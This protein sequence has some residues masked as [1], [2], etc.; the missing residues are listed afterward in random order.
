L[1]YIKNMSKIVKKSLIN[2]INNNYIKAIKDIYTRNAFM[3]ESQS[4]LICTHTI[5]GKGVDFYLTF[6]KN[7]SYYYKIGAWYYY[8][9]QKNRRYKIVI[10][11]NI[12]NNF[13]TNHYSDIHIRIKA[14]LI[15]EI[16]HHLQKLKAPTREHLPRKNYASILDYAKSPSELEACLKHMYFIHKKTKISFIKLI[17]E[18]ASIISDD[19]SIQDVFI[20]N[21]S[22]Y[23]MA[24]TDLNLFK[25]IKG[26]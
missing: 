14:C 1:F 2:N 3:T 26:F 24:R 19:E 13:T 17:M 12:S 5:Y 23:L 7:E 15:H 18:E 6:V 20:S 10:T 4:E 16:E 25:G 11:L 21:I 9:Q 22:N 8:R